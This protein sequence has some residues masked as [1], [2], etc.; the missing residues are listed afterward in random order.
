ME[1]IVDTQRTFGDQTR[2]FAEVRQGGALYFNQ[3]PEMMQ[4]RSFAGLADAGNFLQP[5]LADVLLAQL[6]VRADHETVRLVAKP[7]DKIQYRIA[8]FE[9][10][11]RTIR[12]KQRLPPGVTVRPFSHRH[13]R[14]A[15]DAKYIEYPAHRI[16]LTQAAVDDDEVRPLRNVVVFRRCVGG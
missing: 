11:R 13:Q 16:Q 10:D 3:R 12:Q 2:K 9:L 1:E 6:A 15:G 14:D 5:R 7:L 4:Q 8:R